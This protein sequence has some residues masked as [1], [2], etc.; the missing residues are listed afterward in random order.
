MTENGITITESGLRAHREAVDL[1]Q[2]AWLWAHNQT[3]GI[4]TAREL[5]I[6]MELSYYKCLSLLCTMSQQHDGE[7]ILSQ[8]MHA[9]IFFRHTK[10]GLP[11]GGLLKSATPTSS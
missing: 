2:A 1:C 8:D 10:S 11:S 4:L 9:G 6:E 3:E 5:V 7:L